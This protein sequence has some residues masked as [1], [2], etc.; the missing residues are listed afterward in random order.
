MFVGLVGLLQRGPAVHPRAPQD[1]FMECCE[2]VK[3]TSE[4]SRSRY[5]HPPFAI[6]NKKI[7]G[8]VHAPLEDISVVPSL[9]TGKTIPDYN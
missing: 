3:I 7:V 9:K 6:G 5:C 4:R 8:L 1:T 2:G